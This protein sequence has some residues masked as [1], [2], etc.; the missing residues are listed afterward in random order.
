MNPD[1]PLPEDVEE[2]I[3]SEDRAVKIPGS[4]RRCPRPVGDWSRSGDLPHPRRLCPGTTDSHHPL[5]WSDG[6]NSILT[7][8]EAMKIL[9]RQRE[10]C[11]WTSHQTGRKATIIAMAHA[12][13]I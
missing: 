8:T 10:G 5:A 4:T 2:E 7:L 13:Q 6:I 11:L 9:Q 3:L 12:K 1:E